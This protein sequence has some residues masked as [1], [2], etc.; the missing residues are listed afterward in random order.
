MREL[1]VFLAGQKY[2][3]QEVLG[4]LMAM[5]GIEVVGVSAPPAHWQKQDRLW[6]R[7]GRHRL[8]RVPAGCLGA[9]QIPDGVDLVV[10]AHCHDFI[11]P[12]ALSKTTLGGIAYHPSLLPRHRGRDAVYW[13][14]HMM[15][16]IAGGTV[17]WLNTKVDGGPIA[18]QAHCFVRPGDTPFEL[19]V[20]DLQPL[21]VALLKKV[22]TDIQ[23]GLIVAVAQ[24]EALSSWEPSVGRAPLFRPD[25][26]LIGPAP[27]GFKVLVTRS[28]L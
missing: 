15:D 20:R 17:Y 19:W 1:K 9:V 22:L 7:A 13:T 10:A 18:A 12:K 5:P 3:G 16:S 24:D 2:F 4:M 26:P 28:A 23:S 8:L 14:V 6:Q 11:S 21:G 25:L 27:E